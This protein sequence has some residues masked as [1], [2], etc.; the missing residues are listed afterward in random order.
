MNPKS[1]QQMQDEIDNLRAIA[2]VLLCTVDDLLALPFTLE[3]PP[4]F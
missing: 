1:R 2:E 4:G 3:P